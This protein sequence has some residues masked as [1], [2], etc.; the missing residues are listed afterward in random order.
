M[1]PPVRFAP[2]GLL[3]LIFHVLPWQCDNLA[4]MKTRAAFL[5]FFLFLA[6]PYFLVAQ[7]ASKARASHTPEYTAP[8]LNVRLLFANCAL[9]PARCSKA[10]TFLRICSARAFTFYKDEIIQ[11]TWRSETGLV[12]EAS[13]FVCCAASITKVKAGASPPTAPRTAMNFL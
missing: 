3:S 2:L 8:A 11:L 13:D 4:R 7:S 9:K 10:S 6:V 12:Y 1:E 5:A